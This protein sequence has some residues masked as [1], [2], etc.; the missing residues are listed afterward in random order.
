MQA[1][2]LLTLLSYVHLAGTIR[3][4]RG[5]IVH[6]GKRSLAL[7]AK[8][9]LNMHRALVIRE[10]V[11]PDSRD[12]VGSAI[13]P[14]R[15]T[16]NKNLFLPAN[17]SS[18][19]QSINFRTLCRREMSRYNVLPFSEL[20]SSARRSMKREVCSCTYIHSIHG[21]E[22]NFSHASK[23]PNVRKLEKR[24]ARRTDFGKRIVRVGK[25][26]CVAN[27]YISEITGCAIN[28]RT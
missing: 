15:K 28:F 25:I 2:P 11:S 10:K 6:I 9:N 21:A 17:F 1:S 24:M 5:R 26:L 18:F 8:C 12:D 7:L 23:F 20:F 3:K 19:E 22:K 16:R 14:S 4:S 27:S 13:S